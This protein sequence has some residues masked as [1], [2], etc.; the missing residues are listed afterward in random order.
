MLF[1]FCLFLFFESRILL[2][3]FVATPLYLYFAVLL[4]QGKVAVY[5]HSCW[6]Q[7]VFRHRFGHYKIIIN[8]N[9]APLFCAVTLWCYATFIILT[10]FHLSDGSASK[11]I[12]ITD[13]SGLTDSIFYFAFSLLQVFKWILFVKKW[14]LEPSNSSQCLK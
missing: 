5:F 3:N 9:D 1:I 8:S 2:L 13:C 4:C 14:T 11:K 7:N 12:V 6:K 10:F